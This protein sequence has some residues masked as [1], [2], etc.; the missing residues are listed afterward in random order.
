[1]TGPS[2]AFG[3]RASVPQPFADASRL[4]KTVTVCGLGLWE[5]HVTEDRCV[6]DPLVCDL[7]GLAAGTS[8]LP[9]RRLLRL[10]HQSDRAGLAQAMLASF[11]SNSEVAR[12]VRVCRHDSG[13]VRWL[14]LKACIAER[15]G[16]GEPLIVAGLAFDVT[17]R[18][19]EQ[20]ARELLNQ[21]LAHRMKNMLS[22]VGSIVT[23]SGEH[24][25]EAREF[26]ASLQ[27]R[28]ASL[29]ATHALLTQVDWRPIALGQLFE[30][31]LAPLG[32]IERIDV[33]GHHDFLLG[34]HDAQ[35]LALVLHELATNAIKYG[36]LS[37]GAGRVAL[38]VEIIKGL[39]RDEQP[40]LVLRWE[41]IGGPAV[42]EP[43]IKGFGLTLLER[44]TRRNAHVEPVLQWGAG[45]F[46]CSLSMRMT[47]TETNR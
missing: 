46:V 42:N 28:L 7:L 40:L 11:D 23:M 34:A 13:D 33:A 18:R 2:N 43:S 3:A 38:S 20:E 36:A 29:A 31:V 15:D 35:T 1:M 22:V 12:E 6:I 21:E 16:D 4:R 37:N 39:R 44:L 30:K 9:M 26:I 10:V 27:S 41:E 8:S 24:R 25:P 32:V 5:W 19:Q 45:G 17:A 47:A 14:A